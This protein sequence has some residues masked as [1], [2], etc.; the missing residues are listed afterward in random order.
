[1]IDATLTRK[2]EV[3]IMGGRAAEII[4]SIRTYSIVPDSSGDLTTEEIRLSTPHFTEGVI[5]GV[6]IACSSGN[7]AISL[8]TSPDLTLPSIEEVYRYILINER[9]S[10]NGLDIWY[11]NP[12]PEEYLY[13]VITNSDGVNATGTVHLELVIMEG[14]KTLPQQLR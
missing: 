12:V 1:M 6:R 5:F 7:Y 13:V 9:H 2:K 3:V 8:R 10:E 4:A 14:R 11:F